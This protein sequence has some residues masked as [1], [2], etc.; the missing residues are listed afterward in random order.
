VYIKYWLRGAAGIAGELAAMASTLSS[1]AEEIQRTRSGFDQVTSNVVASGSAASDP[2]RWSSVAQRQQEPLPMVADPLQLWRMLPALSHLP[3]EMLN[4]LSQTEIFQLNS[5]FLTESKV[6]GKLQANA[7][8]T[9]NAQQIINNPV[10]V[11]SG[12]DDRK[13][14]LHCARFLGGASCSSQ[15]LWLQVREFL[16]QKGSQLL[17]IMTWIASAAGGE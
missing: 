3:E 7:K 17:V 12:T 6:A 14:R 8:L 4:Q 11:P 9:M 2:D 13:D 5:A 15:M 10:Q 16:V 1:I